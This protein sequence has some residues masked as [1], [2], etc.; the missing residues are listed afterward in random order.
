MAQQR[1]EIYNSLHT[2]SLFYN[3]QEE[4]KV[5]THFRITSG[6]EKW[7]RALMT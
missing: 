5:V 3:L 1:Q 4:G 2:Q 7:D 6:K